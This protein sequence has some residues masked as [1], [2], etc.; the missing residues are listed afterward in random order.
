M[1]SFLPSLAQLKV[2]A[3]V[4]VGFDNIDVS[5]ADAA[6]VIVTNTPGVLDRASAD[7]TFALILDATRRISEGDR[8]IRRQQPWVWGPRMLVGLDVSAGGATGRARSDT[9]PAHRERRRSDP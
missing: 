4:A 9:H 5:A 6:G 8:L 7:H 2:I 3:N 1:Q